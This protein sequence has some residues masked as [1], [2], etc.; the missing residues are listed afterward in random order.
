M[1]AWQAIVALW[2]CLLVAAVR[3]QPNLLSNGDQEEDVFVYPGDS[4]SKG[5]CDSNGT[6]T[7]C[8]FQG[9]AIASI[10]NPGAEAIFQATALNSSLQLA[11][12]NVTGQS[13]GCCEAK[14]N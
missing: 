9:L 8:T 4:A 5:Q 14:A 11:S 10:S 13:G 1:N 3:G 6:A 12:F 7:S 2:I